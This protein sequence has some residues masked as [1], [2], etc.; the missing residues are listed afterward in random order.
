[1]VISTELFATSY[2]VDG[3]NVEYSPQRASKNTF[4]DETKPSKTVE[5]ISRRIGLATRMKML[6]KG[7]TWEKIQVHEY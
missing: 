3:Q 5:I 4:I 7:V 2:H 1:M 6:E